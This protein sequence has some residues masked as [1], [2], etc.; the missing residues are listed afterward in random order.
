[1]GD[2]QETNRQILSCF[3]NTGK[4]KIF[5]TLLRNF[6]ENLE[7]DILAEKIISNLRKYENFLQNF[8]I[9][10]KKYLENS[11]KM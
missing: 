4:L 2:L 1:M 10:L 11:E 7:E 3:D 8:Q 9:N 5:W 6:H